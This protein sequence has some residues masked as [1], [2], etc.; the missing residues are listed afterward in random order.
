MSKKF[1]DVLKGIKIGKSIKFKIM[2]C[3]LSV[4][5]FLVALSVIS[6]SI[7][8]NNMNKY[9]GLL[10]NL[11]TENQIT[12]ASIEI[13]EVVRGIISNPDDKEKLAQVEAYKKNVLKEN[14]A[15]LVKSS[16]ET[17]ATLKS[18]SNTINSFIE[19][20]D[21]AVAS[22]Q[23]GEVKATNLYTDAS[24]V[25]EYIKN[26]S[27]DLTRAELEYGKV[28]RQSIDK[29]FKVTQTVLISFWI[30]I[31]LLGIFVTVLIVNSIINSL[32]KIIKLS[33]KIAGGDLAS[34][35]LIIDSNDEIGKL[36]NAF[37]TMKK[38]LVEI[39][40]IITSSAK[41]I[42]STVDKL[43]T[44][45]SENFLSNQELVKVVQSTA[46][47]ADN[48][49][50]MVKKSVNSIADINESVKS[51]FEEAQ[52]V[53]NSADAA[54]NKAVAGELKIKEVIN[55]TGIV[56][57]RLTELNTTTDGLYNSSLKIGKIVSIING[58]S[59]Q[60]NL[61]AL[62][63]A[64]EAAR[65]GEAGRGFAVVSDEVRKL[66][67]QSRQS[68]TEITR[69]IQDIQKQ[70]EEMKDGMEKCV[71]GISSTTSIASEQGEAFRGII[72]ANE[73][74]N[75]QIVSINKRL[76]ATRENV[77]KIN[78]ASSVIS[79]LTNEL[80]GSSSQALASIEQQFASQE[81]INKSA[82]ELKVMSLEFDKFVEKFKIN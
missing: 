71:V 54:L 30:F 47:C 62:N 58:I 8:I 70:I 49:S 64:I 69:I 50:G 72:S 6:Q 22:A 32:G 4:I 48:Q 21:I 18:F 26:N 77:N 43:N 66:A 82:S 79:D 78:D 9:K 14:N 10:D 12:L 80:A 36:N 29:S 35:D 53:I 7:Y 19:K 51:V 25:V 5:V 45:T 44:I 42:Q 67:E 2:T 75:S 16:K 65:A 28:L 76:N 38:G 34:A 20:I 23:K 1:K 55:Q 15:L 11:Q 68:S 40:G 81:D 37:N 61:L 56:H 46:S 13:I 33:E 74:V 63:A 17:A 39:V 24:R 27:G 57:N 31:I 52:I 60:T 41:G 3:L 59:D 73:I